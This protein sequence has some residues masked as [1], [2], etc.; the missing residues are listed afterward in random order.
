MPPVVKNM[1]VL[2]FYMSLVSIPTQWVVAVQSATF[3]R[4][5]K[6]TWEGPREVAG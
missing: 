2:V 6:Y 1:L 3:P 4:G 5:P